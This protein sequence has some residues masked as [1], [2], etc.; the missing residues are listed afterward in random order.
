M[1]SLGLG[2][3]PM[4][5]EGLPLRA[6]GSAPRTF[7]NGLIKAKLDIKVPVPGS[8]SPGGGH[9]YFFQAYWVVYGHSGYHRQMS[10]G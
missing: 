1:E 6:W 3:K 10:G 4:A 7:N 8:L 5:T 9:G 2:K